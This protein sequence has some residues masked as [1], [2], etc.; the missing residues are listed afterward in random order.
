MSPAIDNVKH[1]L[2]GS[3]N[4]AHWAQEI[5][6]TLQKKGVWRIANG[7]VQVPPEDAD[8]EVLDRWHEK[9]DVAKGIIGGAVA[10]HIYTEIKEMLTSSEMWLHLVSYSRLS[11]VQTAQL[12]SKIFNLKYDGS[13]SLGKHLAKMKELRSLLAE[14]GH[15]ISNIVFNC[16]VIS[17]L[18]TV[19]NSLVDAIGATTL[20][21]EITTAE[22]ERKL[23]EKESQLKL[24]KAAQNSDAGHK[25]NAATA[26]TKH[27]SRCGKCGSKDHKT[28]DCKGKVKCFRCNLEGHIA[29]DC[30]DETKEKANVAVE[31]EVNKDMSIWYL[32]SGSTIHLTPRKDLFVEI[33]YKRSIDIS[34]AKRGQGMK[35][36]GLG[37]VEML[38][39]DRII[40]LEDVAYV[41]DAE[42]NLLSVTQLMRRGISM[43][44]NAETK[45]GWLLKNTERIAEVQLKNRLPC[46]VFNDVSHKSC[47]VQDQASQKLQLMH[48]RY[49]HV[50]PQ[51]LKKIADGNLVQNIPKVDSSRLS[52]HCDICER[53]K[54]T[55]KS[56][57]E[58]H[59]WAEAKDVGDRI[60]CDIKQVSVPGLK[61]ERNKMTAKSLNE[62]H[63]W[64]EAKDVGDRIH[65]DIKQVSV[66]GLKGERYSI[67]FIDEYS[68]Y[69]VTYQCKTKDDCASRFETDFY[70]WFVNQTGKNIKAFVSDNAKELISGSNGLFLKNHG[71]ELH[72]SPEYKAALNGKAERFNRT[73]MECCNCLLDQ[74]NLAHKFWPYAMQAAVFLLNRSYSRKGVSGKTAFEV[75]YGYKPDYRHLRVFGCKAVVRIPDV[76]RSDLEHRAVD[77]IFVGYNQRSW[78]LLELESLKEIN[79]VDVKFHEDEFVSDKIVQGDTQE[80]LDVEGSDYHMSDNESSEDEDVSDYRRVD[81]L[82]H[83]EA[84][85]I[86]NNIE[87]QNDQEVGIRRSARIQERQDRN[88]VNFVKE[89]RNYEPRS[90]KD[91]LKCPDHDKWV[92]AIQ[93]EIDALQSEKTWEIVKRPDNITAIPHKWVF[94]VKERDD[95]S[96]ARYKGRLVACGNF[97][98]K[99]VNY[100]ELFAPVIRSDSLRL[101]IAIAAKYDL[102]MMHADVNSA[103]VQSDMDMDVYLTIPECI[104][105]KEGEVFLLRKSIYGLKQSG[106]NWNKKLVSVLTKVGFIQSK[107]EPSIFFRKSDNQLCIIGAYVDDLLIISKS[108]EDNNSIFKL[109]SSELKI[110]VVSTGNKYTIAGIQVH[111]LSDKIVVHQLKYVQDKLFEFGLQNSKACDTPADMRSLSVIMQPKTEKEKMQMKNIP[112]KSAVGSLMY[113][114]TQTR[115]DISFAVNQTARF[116]SNPGNDHWVAVKRIFRYL[117]STTDYGIT[118]YKAGSQELVGYADASFAS[119]NDDKKSIS[120]CIF[121][122]AG[123]PICWKSKKQTT[124]APSTLASEYISLYTCLNEG[125][126][127]KYLMEE[128]GVFTQNNLTIYE[129]NQSCIKLAKDPQHISNAKHLE[130]KYHFTREKV[131]SGEVGLVY[132]STKDMIAD[133]LTKSLPRDQFQKLR[134]GSVGINANSSL[135]DS[136]QTLPFWSELWL[137][138]LT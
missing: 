22:L 101:I 12:F 4:Y 74:S 54:M 109:I 50:N 135:V 14:Q 8:P 107:I 20:G 62:E 111:V 112:Y 67:C 99:D 58:E 28:Y 77:C 51:Y 64:A 121:L 69:A 132:V 87:V 60:H 88:R 68:N 120:G 108:N 106:R 97:Q 98:T 76:H 53:N 47:Q 81:R 6:A 45:S 44:M 33:D 55:A 70:P 78:K 42:L 80:G 129:D 21:L 134:T 79:S 117:K 75:I 61:G 66:P 100:K 1:V 95:G 38:Y 96:V 127:L 90:Y 116:F 23:M 82:I 130:I 89:K 56:L 57:N 40:R 29:R 35:A 9:N 34:V 39:K 25:A 85:G 110:K 19:Y 105:H 7:T 15:E 17:S 18:P 115:P 126:W 138:N 59:T 119:C 52:V 137:S 3:S 32:D 36:V 24:S 102:K 43:Q 92:Q 5:K 136:I 11:L 37:T 104:P 65:C 84:E 10:P 27:G 72:S 118:Y 63:T 131:Q 31:E 114:S 103:Y 30:K 83:R 2:Q 71:I 91:A 123:G 133:M 113:V 94:S 13:G 86:I 125:L 122:F 128:L 93:E 49:G 26:K 41:P 124:I 73:S 16:A 46:I 48:Q